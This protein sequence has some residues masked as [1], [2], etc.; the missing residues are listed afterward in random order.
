[1][2]FTTSKIEI[3]PIYDKFTILVENPAYTFNTFSSDTSFSN[4]FVGS[5]KK[6]KIEKYRLELF[7]LATF[8]CIQIS[9]RVILHNQYKRYS[10]N[11]LILFFSLSWSQESGGYRN[12]QNVTARVRVPYSM[13]YR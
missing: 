1:M 6:K 12:Q 7:E 3:L 4:A 9:L 2:N 10:I 13:R 5:L 11:L 8:Q